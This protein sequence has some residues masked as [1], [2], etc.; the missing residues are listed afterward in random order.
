MSEVLIKINLETIRNLRKEK[1]ISVKEIIESLKLKTKSAYY[2]KEL[3]INDFKLEEAKILACMLKTSIEQLFFDNEC[4][5]MEQK[6]N[7]SKGA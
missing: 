1:K 7:E 6:T 3:G 4:S 2:R 5:K